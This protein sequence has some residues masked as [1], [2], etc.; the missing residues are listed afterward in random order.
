[1]SDEP[2][3]PPARQEFARALFTGIVFA[4]CVLIGFTALILALSL[5]YLRIRT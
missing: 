2:K 1:M 5:P 3:K 4:I